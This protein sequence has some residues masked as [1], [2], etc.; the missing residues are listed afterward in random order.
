[1]IYLK[2]RNR[3]QSWAIRKGFNTSLIEELNHLMDLALIYPISRP[4]LDKPVEIDRGSFG[5]IFRSYYDGSPVAIKEMSK[6]GTGALASCMREILLEL[7]NLVQIRHPFI[8]TY[9]GVAMEFPE[10]PEGEPYLGIVFELCEHGSLH[11]IIFN[12]ERSRMRDFGIE[13][14]VAVAFHVAAGLSYLHSRRIIHRF[15]IDLQDPNHS[16]TVRANGW[17]LPLKSTMPPP[18]SAL[19]HSP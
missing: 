9:W 16:V 13:R 19:Y 17:Q 15:V 1:M 6:D 3:A 2:F 8:V 7:R 4:N 5:K 18:N 11:S 12:R 14:K 10:T